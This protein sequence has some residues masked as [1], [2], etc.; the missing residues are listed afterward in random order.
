MPG[1]RWCKRVYVAPTLSSVSAIR[2]RLAQ[3]GLGL[4]QASF[5]AGRTSPVR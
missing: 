2:M 1:N 3:N 4:L 5:S